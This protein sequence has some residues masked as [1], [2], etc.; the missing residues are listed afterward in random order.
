MLICSRYKDGG[1]KKRKRLIF[2]FVSVAP[3]GGYQ[4]VTHNKCQQ[5][6]EF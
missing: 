3:G 4:L 6:Y 2:G 5:Y 1:S